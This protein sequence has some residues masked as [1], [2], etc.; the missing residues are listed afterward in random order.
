MVTLHH[1]FLDMSI[2]NFLKKIRNNKIYFT[3]ACVIGGILLLFMA[4][5]LTVPS[6]SFNDIEP[7][8]GEF[9]NNPYSKIDR[10][11]YY[12]FRSQNIENEGINSYEYGYS[13]SGARYLCLGYKD[14]RKIDYP[15]LQNIHFKQYNIDQLNKTS[16]LVALAHPSDG[17]R[18][19][20]LTRLDHYR[21]M[22]ALSPVDNSLYYWDI[23]LSNGHRVNI[24]ATTG[25]DAGDNSETKFVTACIGSNEP[26]SVFKALETGNS[27]A[28]AYKGLLAEVPQLVSVKLRY[29]N[30]YVNVSKVAKEMRFIGQNAEVKK[31]VNNVDMGFYP[32]SKDDTY[33]RTEIEFEDGTVLYLN[34]LVRHQYEYFYDLNK[35]KVMK[36][37]T[38]LM[39][40]VYIIVVV[41][42][43]R[44]LFIKKKHEDTRE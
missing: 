15:F 43:V 35:A 10:I 21:V 20:E 25:D 19:V 14:K 11:N 4:L 18:Q 6:Y 26:D 44:W 12:D 41:A 9:I 31:V 22:E 42:M 34:P 1:K 28:V 3:I 8:K 33:V 36:G 39:W 37:R 29:D 30:L 5:Y 13:L 40:G 7:F 2:K 24:I 38:Y 16:R 17:F 27:Y 23:A 32:I